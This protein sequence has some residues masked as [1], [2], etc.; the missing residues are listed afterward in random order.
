MTEPVN[1]KDAAADNRVPMH[2]LPPVGIVYGAMA[3]MDG[4][5]KYGPYNWRERA[6]SLTK[7]VGAIKRHLDSLLD[8]EDDAVDSRLPHLAHVLATAAI[9]LDAKEAGALIDDRPKRSANTA[10]LIERMNA[11]VKARNEP[12]VTSD[13]PYQV[14]HDGKPCVFD[15]CTKVCAEERAS[16]LRR[17]YPDVVYTVK[18]VAGPQAVQPWL[19]YGD[20]QW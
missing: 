15:P 6:I 18:Q 13:G 17:L 7:Y 2:L 16:E 12:S 8:G 20:E 1:P 19:E 5:L 11:M 4:A 14:Y 3:C 9:M 10:R